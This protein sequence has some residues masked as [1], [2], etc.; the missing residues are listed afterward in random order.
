MAVEQHALKTTLESFVSRLIQGVSRSALL[1]AFPTKAIT[2]ID[3]ERFRIAS[4][5]VPEQLVAGVA[6][7]A[8]P[9]RLRFERFADPGRAGED[10]RALFNALKAKLSREAQLVFRETGLR[11]LWLAYPILYVPNPGGDASDFLLAPLFLWPLR[12]L[13]SG[14]PEGEL[15]I[16]RDPDGGGPRFNRAAMQWVRRYLDFDPQEPSAS[17]VRDSESL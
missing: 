11:T 12:I 14:L 4:T 7:P 1:K 17:D 5:D 15:I 2:R 9:V 16:S 8:Q 10:S 13:A 3:L 6:S